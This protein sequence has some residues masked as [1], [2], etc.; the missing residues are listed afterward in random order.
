MAKWFQV[1]GPVSSHRRLFG[2][3]ISDILDEAPG[4]IV[5]MSSVF[6]EWTNSGSIGQYA[7]LDCNRRRNVVFASG[8]I[9]QRDPR[10]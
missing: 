1:L 10:G 7:H 8:S 9:T 6:I 3:W 5:L 4:I 2:V